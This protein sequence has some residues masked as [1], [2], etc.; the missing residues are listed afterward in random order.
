MLRR[1]IALELPR[2][3]PH[4]LAGLAVAWALKAFNSRA[5]ADD[6]NW[7]LEPASRLAGLLGGI[8][9]ERETGAGWVSHEHG[10]IVGPACAGLNFLIIAFATCYFSVLHR[11]SRPAARAAWLPASLAAA[12][13]LTIVVN[14]QRI[15][16]T[17]HLKH[18]DIYGEVITQHRVHRAAGAMIYCFALLL[19]HEAIVRIV[20]PR[21]GSAIVPAASP[22]VPIAWYLSVT[23]AGPILNRAWRNAPGEF[24]EHSVLVAACSLLAAATFVMLRARMKRRPVPPSDEVRC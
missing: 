21:R 6:L 11:L 2:L 1:F 16:A 20:P 12:C 17:V 23:L 24:L 22:L 5:G 15:I 3:V 8:A 9:F 4:H 18:W 19:F 7:I 10:V 14:A 13:A